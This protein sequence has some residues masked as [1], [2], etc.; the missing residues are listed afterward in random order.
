M[1]DTLDPNFFKPEKNLEFFRL[2]ILGPE[3]SILVGLRD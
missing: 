2:K 3:M 1:D